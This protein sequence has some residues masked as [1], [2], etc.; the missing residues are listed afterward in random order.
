MLAMGLFG[1]D[2]FVEKIKSI[3]EI[4]ITVKLSA[5]IFIKQPIYLKLYLSDSKITKFE[6][7]L[8]FFIEEIS[9]FINKKCFFIIF[10]CFFK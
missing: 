10:Y 9:L 4:K 8:V 3:I 1:V 6:N 2:Y 7:S 5:K